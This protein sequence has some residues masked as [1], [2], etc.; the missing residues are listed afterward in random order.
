M[1][2][3]FGLLSCLIAGLAVIGIICLGRDLERLERKVD[4]LSGGGAQERQP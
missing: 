4:R 1:A 3:Y 2:T